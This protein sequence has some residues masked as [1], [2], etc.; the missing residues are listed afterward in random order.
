MINQDNN[1]KDVIKP[2]IVLLV[3]SVSINK[4]HI[5][6]VLNINRLLC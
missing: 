5:I 1:L 3:D 2:E 4:M 6:L